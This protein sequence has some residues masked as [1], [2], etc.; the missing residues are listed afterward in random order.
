M[1]TPNFASRRPVEMYGCD[2]GSM[3][4][5]TRSETRATAPRAAAAAP[6]RAISSSLSAFHSPIPCSSPRA[7]SASV[8]PT[9]AKTMRSGR[10]PGAPRGEQL[11]ARDD[12]GPRPERGEQA[13]DRPVA[14]GLHRVADPRPGRREGRLVGPEGRLDPG[15]AVDVERRPVLARRVLERHPVA[16]ELAS[17]Y[18][19]P[20]QSRPPPASASRGTRASSCRRSRATTPASPTTPTRFGNT[21][22]P[23]MRS[24]HAH[25]RS[26]LLVAPST[27]SP[28]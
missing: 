1:S 15:A 27:T 5:L 21:C 11:A 7:I 25:T 20:A 9:P 10:E 26:T 24:P 23:F 8:L 16:P 19:E 18:L 6:I 28:Q 17:R 2:R 3:S 4:G 22:S 14:V 13:Q 12:V